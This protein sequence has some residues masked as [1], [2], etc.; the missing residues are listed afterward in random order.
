MTNLF[1]KVIAGTLIGL[2]LWLCVSKGNKDIATLLTIAISAIVLLVAMEYLTAFFQ[3]V[4]K[5]QSIA[6]IKSE[7][8]SILFKAVGIGFISEVSSIICKDAGNE[9]IGK[10]IQIFSVITILILSIPA[11]DQLL[12]LLQDILGNI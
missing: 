12:S 5:I 3:F 10:S 2:I 8:L 11:F 6:N 1:L 9:S 7:L 4:E